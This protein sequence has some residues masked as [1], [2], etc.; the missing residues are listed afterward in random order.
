L[1]DQLGQLDAILSVTAPMVARVFGELCAYLVEFE[2]SEHPIHDHIIAQISRFNKA[3][4]S[5][6]PG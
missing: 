1:E 4:K 3:L 5:S 2:L 6:T